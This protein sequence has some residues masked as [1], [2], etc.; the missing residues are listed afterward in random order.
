M[1]L[2]FDR[3]RDTS[4]TVRG[5]KGKGSVDSYHIEHLKMGKRV[6]IRLT[7]FISQWSM[8]ESYQLRRRKAEGVLEV[9]KERRYKMVFLKNGWPLEGK[10]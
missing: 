6:S 7:T 2:T 5:G 1:G 3:N 8:S 9:C 4:F 10:L